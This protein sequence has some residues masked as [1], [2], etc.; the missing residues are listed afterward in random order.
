MFPDRI[1]RLVIDDDLG[2]LVNDTNKTIQW[3][4]GGCHA[5]G[6]ENCAFYASSPTKIEAALDDIY[7]SLRSQPLPVFLNSDLYDILT[8]DDLRS[9][10]MVAL[11]SPSNFPRLAQKLAELQAGNAT[12]V[13]ELVYV[14]QYHYIISGVGS[15]EAMAAIECGNSDPFNAD[16]SVEGVYVKN[17]FN[18]CRN[19]GGAVYESLRRMEDSPQASLQRYKGSLVLCKPRPALMSKPLTGPVGAA[20]TSHPLLVIGNTADPATPLAGAKKTSLSFPGSVLLTQDFPEHSSINTNSTCT[21]QHVAAYFANG[22]LPEEGT[23]CS[24]DAPLFLTSANATVPES[25]R[26]AS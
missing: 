1:E 25:P 26:S 5:A 24:L 21:H 20:N 10:T 19:A 8:Y 2:G 3:F 22:T 4:L 17:Q 6:P 11:Y 15:A 16:A 7:D 9:I 14:F 18:L 23:V 12:T 13:F